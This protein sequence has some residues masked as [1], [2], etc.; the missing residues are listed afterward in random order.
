MD[1][2]SGRWTNNAGMDQGVNSAPCPVYFSNN[3]GI[4]RAFNGPI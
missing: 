2:D 1:W 4:N 3:N